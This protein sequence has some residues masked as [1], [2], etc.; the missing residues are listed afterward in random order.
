MLSIARAFTIPVISSHSHQP[1]L[2]PITR[3]GPNVITRSQYHRLVE[4]DADVTLDTGSQVNLSL[5]VELDTDE[6]SSGLLSTVLVGRALEELT[7]IIVSKRIRGSDWDAYQRAGRDRWRWAE[8]Q[9]TAASADDD[10]R[11]PGHRTQSRRRKR[12]WRDCR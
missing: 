7:C 3:Y 1:Y 8:E 11:E 9:Q 6:Q 5:E 4:T 10:R 12:A 2:R